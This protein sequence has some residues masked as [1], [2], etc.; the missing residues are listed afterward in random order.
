MLGGAAVGGRE[1]AAEQARNGPAKP[2]DR[3]VRVA[4]N[5][6]PR[7]PRRR[8]DEPQQLE[9]G[10]VDVLE[11]VDEDQAKLRLK[12]LAQG[13]VRLQQRDRAGDEVAEVEHPRLL[14]A[15]LVRLVDR[16][17]HPESLGGAGFG[18]EDQ[19]GGVHQVLLHQSN[20][21]QDIARECI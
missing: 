21:R 5:D 17:Q 15:E 1:V 14:Q 2:V 10:G 18:R 4:H 6:Q 13:L 11:L 20:K 12:P 19:C 8:G 7:T 16:G 9:L 3:L